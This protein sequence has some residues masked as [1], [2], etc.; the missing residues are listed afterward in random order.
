[1][2]RPTSQMSRPASR[3]ISRCSTPMVNAEPAER[4]LKDVIFRHWKDMQ[5]QCR[6]LDT[7]NTGTISVSDFSGKQ[8][9]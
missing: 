8:E 7:D 6:N 1:M 5:H 9:N 4:L 3:S 2:P